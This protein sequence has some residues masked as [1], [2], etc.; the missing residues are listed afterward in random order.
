MA[1]G[2]CS[3]S[4]VADEN[5]L[6]LSEARA[7]LTEVGLMRDN[8]PTPEALRYGH[9]EVYEGQAW[10]RVWFRARYEDWKR[11][12]TPVEDEPVCYHQ[13]PMDELERRLAALLA[14]RQ[15]RGTK[16]YSCAAHDLR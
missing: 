8:R 1:N 9:A 7:F 15:L 2:R 12:S 4:M 11:A 6:T 5:G 13:M 16:Q 14:E 10:D 3:L